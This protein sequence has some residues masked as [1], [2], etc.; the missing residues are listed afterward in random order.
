[1]GP[2]AALM[3]SDSLGSDELATAHEGDTYNPV[4]PGSLPS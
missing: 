3:A 4:D 1:M 2:G